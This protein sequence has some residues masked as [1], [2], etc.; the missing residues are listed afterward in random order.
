MRHGRTV[1]AVFDII[2]NLSFTSKT[3]FRL[4]PLTASLRQNNLNI[5]C[6]GYAST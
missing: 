5:S 3:V 1:Q 6:R 2:S 4:K